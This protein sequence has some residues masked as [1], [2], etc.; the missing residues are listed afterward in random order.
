MPLND[1]VIALRL[2]DVKPT[3]LK[4]GQIAELFKHFS[5][6][7][8]NKDAKFAYIQEGSSYFGNSVNAHYLADIKEEIL[9]SAG[10]EL[11]RFLSKH[12]DW[13]DAAIGFHSLGE[14]PQTM[15]V[16]REVSFVEKPNKFKQNDTLRGV[17][18]GLTEGKD[19]TDHVGIS[20]LNGTTL[21]AKTTE[22]V[23]S[24]L[25]AYFRTN[26]IIE[27]TGIAT[28]SYSDDFVLILEDF[29]IQS[30]EPLATDSVENWISDFVGFGRSGWQDLSD[31]LKTLQKERHS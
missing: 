4:I 13:G 5:S 24:S 11:D 15:T 30:F 7:L 12:L 31:P 22:L 9:N 3:E 19:A 14:S 10:G 8:K 17:L 28:Y 26:T 27:F 25:K 16:I 20:F 1:I 21:S 29:T 6:L 23:A 18:K 2:P